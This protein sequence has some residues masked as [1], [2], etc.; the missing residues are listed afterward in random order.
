MLEMRKRIS[1]AL[2]FNCCWQQQIWRR[3]HDNASPE[4][5]EELAASDDHFGSFSGSSSISFVLSPSAMM[6]SSEV[7]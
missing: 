2:P 6:N 1:K 4:E 5:R 3:S 7:K